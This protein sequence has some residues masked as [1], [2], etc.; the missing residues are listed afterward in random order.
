MHHA[1]VQPDWLDKDSP[2]NKALDACHKANIGLV[3]MK[4]IAGSGPADHAG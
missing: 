2:L 4:Q 1:Q 3:S